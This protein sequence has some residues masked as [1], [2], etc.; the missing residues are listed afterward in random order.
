MAKLLHI[1]ASPRGAQSRTLG[2]SNEFLNG[3]KEKNS[4]LQV[5]E[6]DLFRTN[7]P[8]IYGNSVDAKYAIMR[9]GS[10]DDGMQNSWDEIVR[11]SSDFLTYDYYLISN[12]MWNFTVPYKL[13]H[14]ID[15]IMQPGILLKFSENGVEGLAK[16]KKM[17]CVT[18]R[19]SDYSAGS[20]MNQFDFQ[21]PYLRSIFG[22]AGIVDITFINAQP[23]DISLDLTQLSLN[24][25]KDKVDSISSDLIL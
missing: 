19:G 18:S 23:L 20:Y 13:K 9:G 7:L 22:L 3:I 5:T 2:I 15:V 24:N 11:Y 14:Y 8:E 4:D 17:F 21:E 1:I 10:L 25:A 12:P 6:L 16:G